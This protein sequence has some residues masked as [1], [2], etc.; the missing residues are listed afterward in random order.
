M[1]DEDDMPD[2]PDMSDMMAGMSGMPGMTGMG[3]D[4]VHSDQ[5][6]HSAE[7]TGNLDDLEEEASK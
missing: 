6:D 7:K 4:H 1:A 5:C 2:M 3:Q